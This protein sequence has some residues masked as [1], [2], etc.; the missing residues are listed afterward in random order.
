MRFSDLKELPYGYDKPTTHLGA[1][2][3]QHVRK[4]VRS[5]K[6]TKNIA[7]HRKE[8]QTTHRYNESPPFH[9][10]QKWGAKEKTTTAG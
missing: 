7:T 5:G 6:Y 2:I 4:K 8:I 10:E 1:E 3:F 9:H